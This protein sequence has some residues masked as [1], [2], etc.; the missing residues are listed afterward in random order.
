MTFIIGLCMGYNPY[1]SCFG[2]QNMEKK[3]GENHH[4]WSFP[5]T[6]AGTGQPVQVQVGFW[7][8]LANLYRYRLDL[9]RYSLGSGRFWPTCTGTG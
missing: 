8:F 9:Y 3:W 2:Y 6:C 7:S 1:Y 4:F 5:K